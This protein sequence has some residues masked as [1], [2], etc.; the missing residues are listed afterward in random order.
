MPTPDD[1]E[2]RRELGTE[3]QELTQAVATLRTEIASAKDIKG[4][5]RTKL[6]AIAAGTAG[7]AFVALGGVRRTLR[8]VTRRAR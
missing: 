7:I 4:K 1:K 6:P 8:L 5:V 2:I 3:R